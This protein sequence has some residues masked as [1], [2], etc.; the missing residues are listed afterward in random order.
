MLTRCDQCG[1]WFR[2]RSEHLEVAQGMVRCGRCG[3]LFNALTTLITDPDAARESERT[4]QGDPVRKDTQEG[5]VPLP[6]N[7]RDQVDLREETRDA[8]RPADC[9]PSSGAG[10]PEDWSHALE[11]APDAVIG[12]ESMQPGM[13]TTSVA[14]RSAEVE[15]AGARKDRLDE[16]YPADFTPPPRHRLRWLWTAGSGLAAL[17]IVIEITAI[18]H[19]QATQRLMRTFAQRPLV[20]AQ[21]GHARIRPTQIS[22][23]SAEVRKMR[24]GS[25]GLR[26]EGTLLNLSAHRTGL[27]ELLVRFTNLNG[28]IVAEGLFGPGSYLTPPESHPVMPAHAGVAF[29]LRVMDPGKQA[30]GFSIRTCRTSPRH[31]VLC[32]MAG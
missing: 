21:S 24:R 7:N 32:S 12:E 3:S 15:P 28:D 29:R 17:V 13:E 8:I 19:H 20:S 11:I 22:V 2:I 4:I 10:D 31:R 18:A 25:H 9:Q 27:P 14:D 6:Q 16:A 5:P 23:L 1:T 30:V 26:I